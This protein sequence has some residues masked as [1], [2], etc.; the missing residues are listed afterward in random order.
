MT[1]S[2]SG[3]AAHRDYDGTRYYFCSAGC[4][5]RFDADPSQYAHQG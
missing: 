5:G 1:I 2:A 4:A 3:A